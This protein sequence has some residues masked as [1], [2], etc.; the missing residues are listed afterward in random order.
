MVENIFRA[1]VAACWMSIYV[2]VYC[3][4]LLKHMKHVQVTPMMA[5]HITL[6]NTKFTKPGLH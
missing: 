3:A 2:K 6:H 1:R 4:L 5:V